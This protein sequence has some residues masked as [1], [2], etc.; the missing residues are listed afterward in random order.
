MHVVTFKNFTV[1]IAIII[2]KK[3]AL[4]EGTILNVCIFFWNVYVL[5]FDLLVI[6]EFSHL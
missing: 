5:N 2:T 6:Q 3:M 1:R 4:T